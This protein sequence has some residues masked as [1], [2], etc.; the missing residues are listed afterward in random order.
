M[1]HSYGTQTAERE[2][3]RELGTK[4][5]VNAKTFKKR[6][7]G[8]FSTCISVVKDQKGLINSMGMS[9]TTSPLEKVTVSNN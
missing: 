4:R 3:E 9:F 6:Y 1:P 7:T 2:R 5:M 8:V